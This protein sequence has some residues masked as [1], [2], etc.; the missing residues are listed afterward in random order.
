MLPNQQLL[1]S[2][3][4]LEEYYKIATA[5]TIPTASQGD[6]ALLCKHA[7]LELCGWLEEMQD[8]LAKECCAVLSEPDFINMKDKFI[9][10]TYGFDMMQH[11]LPMMAFSIG[12][13][14]YEKI[15]KK[16]R[17]PGSKFTQMEGIITGQQYK[18][19]RNRHAHTYFDALNAN[20][21]Q[22][23]N[24]PA[25]VRQNAQMIYEGF[26]ELY[27]ELKLQGFLT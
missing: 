24:S 8:Y 11:F 23:L 6:P 20:K 22:H 9:G 7:A 18:V 19:I 25:V 5:A 17:I 12:V 27:N 15:I 1:Q 2:L 16:L 10:G 14:E 4:A 21:L 13:S 3:D 26:Q